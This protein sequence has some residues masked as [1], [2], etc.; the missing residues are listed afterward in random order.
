VPLLTVATFFGLHLQT[1]PLTLDTP[2][3]PF[4]NPSP[5][6]PN[7]LL[8]V[9]SNSHSSKKTMAPIT[10]VNDKVKV[11]LTGFQVPYRTLSSFAPHTFN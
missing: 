11:V 10:K 2:Y 8:F 3:I 4:F 5:S 7:I 6:Y 1:H 9:N